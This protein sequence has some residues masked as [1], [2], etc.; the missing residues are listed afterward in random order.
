M[1]RADTRFE[2]GSASTGGGGNGLS[3]EPVADWGVQAAAG[4]FA[5]V[6][7]GTVA[8]TRMLMGNTLFFDLPALA[9][10]LAGARHHVCLRTQSTANGV[11]VEQR[12]VRVLAQP[13]GNLAVAMLAAP[14]VSAPAAGGTVSDAGFT[15]DFTPPADATFLV[16]S[17]RSDSG[18][19]LR[20]WTVL[21]PGTARSFAFRR[22]PPDVAQVLAPGRT[23]DLALTAHRVVSGPLLEQNDPYTT[24]LANFVSLGP[25]GLGVDAI[26]RTAFTVST[27]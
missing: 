25:A 20:E 1:L 11:T 24:V 18:G 23:W 2:S 13:D 22:L 21:L 8:V 5:D 16:L 27:P 15:V 19:E 10:P 4:T 17:L 3:G 14:T 6:S 26:A 12:Q 7:R 9:G